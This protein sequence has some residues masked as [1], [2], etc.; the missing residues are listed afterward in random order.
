MYTILNMIA[1]AVHGTTRALNESS[2]NTRA[3]KYN[4][5]NMINDM[6]NKR[7]RDYGIVCLYRVVNGLWCTDMNKLKAFDFILPLSDN[8]SSCMHC[9]HLKYSEKDTFCAKCQVWYHFNCGTQTN[10]KRFKCPNC[11]LEEVLLK[12]K[13]GRKPLKKKLKIN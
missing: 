5:A 4:L 6:L 2:I 7:P 11:G 9:K 8:L 1:F 13:K 10:I 3:I 12:V